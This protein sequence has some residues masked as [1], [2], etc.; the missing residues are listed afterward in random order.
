MQRLLAESNASAGAEGPSCTL[1]VELTGAFNGEYADRIRLT[2]YQ[3]WA[4][5]GDP[6]AAGALRA[7]HTA[8][9]READAITD[10]MLRQSFLQNIPENREI[11]ARWAEGQATL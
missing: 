4:A 6:R 2:I 1:D 7:A 3:V 8:L 10:S 5:A 11:V 9:Q